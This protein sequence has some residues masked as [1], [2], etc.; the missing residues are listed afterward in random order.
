M[1]STRWLN[2]CGKLPTRR[3]RATS[4]S[5]ASRPR[6]LVNPRS[7]FEQRTCLADAPVQ[8]QG[9]HQPERRA[10]AA[11][12]PRDLHRR[13]YEPAAVALVAEQGRETR[14]R[15]ETGQAEPVDRPVMPHERS[16][17][18]AADQAVVLDP[19][20]GHMLVHRRAADKHRRQRVTEPAEVFVPVGV[21][22][23]N[24]ASRLLG[25]RPLRLAAAIRLWERGPRRRPASSAMASG[26]H[27][28]KSKGVATELA[29]SLEPLLQLSAR[30]R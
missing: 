11:R 22:V 10:V 28:V 19:H 6:S 8:G 20:R 23:A 5:S 9:A 26:I 4:Y 17:L 14:R 30:S 3:C 2:A 15:I 27:A 24:V 29:T 25:Y 12:R 7:R 18:Q 13:G 1:E 16:R 21:I